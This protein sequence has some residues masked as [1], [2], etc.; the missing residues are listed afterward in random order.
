VSENFVEGPKNFIHYRDLAKFLAKSTTLPENWAEFFDV[1]S[2]P[3]DVRHQAVMKI[4][5]GSIYEAFC[6]VLSSWIGRL[7]K[8]DVKLLCEKLTDADQSGIAGMLHT[9]T[10]KSYYD[11][12][13]DD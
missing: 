6:E 10:F 1:L 13:A 9:K 3:A 2:L 12:G 4:R 8:C 11:L 7:P 5:Q